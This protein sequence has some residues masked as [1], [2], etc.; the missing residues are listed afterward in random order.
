MIGLVNGVERF[1]GNKIDFSTGIQLKGEHQIY[2]DNTK[3]TPMLTEAQWVNRNIPLYAP[4]TIL[5]QGRTNMCNPFS[6]RYMIE[7]MRRQ[8]GLKPMSVSPGYIYGGINDGK[9][10][11]SAL[12]DA[13]ER[14]C[15]GYVSTE[16]VPEFA[17][18]PQQWPG[19]VTEIAKQRYVTE[20]WLCPTGKHIMS[21]LHFGFTVVVGMIWGEG[22]EPDQDGWLADYMQG[23]PAGGHALCTI[24]PAR[25]GK[26]FGFKTPNTWGKRWGI[27]GWCVLP[28]SRFLSG[29]FTGAWAVRQLNIAKG[30]L[31][32]L[33]LPTE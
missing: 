11:G 2:G 31:D 20:K 25:K 30:D 5:D 17:Y 33:P 19:N 8:M 28:I 21:A 24:A 9:D 22:D 14:V 10:E 7:S 3:V 1:F 27:N 13:M 4:Q 6:C 32:D 18:N 16:V 15:R 26:R 12:E 29:P 23:N